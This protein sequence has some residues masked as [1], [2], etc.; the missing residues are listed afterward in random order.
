MRVYKKL[1]LARSCLL[2]IGSEEI[3]SINYKSKNIWRVM[4]LRGHKS[5]SLTLERPQPMGVFQYTF[6]PIE[7]L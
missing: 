5:S 1:Y 7:V 2:K 3:E 6:I 4:I